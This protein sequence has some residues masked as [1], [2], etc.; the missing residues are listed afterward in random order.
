MRTPL[1]Q[2]SV[3]GEGDLGMINPHEGHELIEKRSM[4]PINPG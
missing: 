4:R 2:V 1:L 3:A